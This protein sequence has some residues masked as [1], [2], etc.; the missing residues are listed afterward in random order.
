MLRSR[1]R[2]RLIGPSSESTRIRLL[3]ECLVQTTVKEAAAR[4]QAQKPPGC[5]CVV[6][7][8]PTIQPPTAPDQL[9]Y[10]LEKAIVCSTLYKSQETINGAQ[11]VYTT[12]IPP[13]TGP[14]VE[15]PQ[16]PAVDLVQRQFQRIRGIEQI[17]KPLV[18]RSSNDRTAALRASIEAA[19]MTRY[20][21]TV[22]P[23]IPYPP[24]VPRRSGPQ[25]GV[26][27]G[28][29]TPCNLANRRVDYSNP[30]A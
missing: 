11:P 13:L 12:P 6:L 24:C 4:A 3:R 14:G 1:Q 16:G 29:S 25:P 15:P 21:Q 19:E 27:P 30:K 26:P 20:S 9:S 17:S 23:V 7:T 22:I 18:G 2:R 28:V 10:V 5:E 8:P